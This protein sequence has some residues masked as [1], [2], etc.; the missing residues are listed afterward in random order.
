MVSMEHHKNITILSYNG[1]K[2][3]P[4]T[5]SPKKVFFLRSEVVIGQ[6]LFGG[7]CDSSLKT[8]MIRLELAMCT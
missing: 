4:S 7:G 6:N 5:N 1:S 3:N 8:T 2:I